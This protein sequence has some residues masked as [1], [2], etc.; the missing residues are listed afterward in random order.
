MLISTRNPLGQLCF[1][2]SSVRSILGEILKITTLVATAKNPNTPK[3]ISAQTEPG[4]G[5]F[6]PP[7]PA[8]R[9]AM[10]G[11]RNREFKSNLFSPHWAPSMPY[12]Q[13]EPR[14]LTAAQ[15]SSPFK[16]EF[17]NSECQKTPTTSSFCLSDLRAR[18]PSRPPGEGILGAAFCFS[19]LSPALVRL[20]IPTK[21]LDS[22][23]NI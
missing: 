16:Q 12:T 1:P 2:S 17:H 11:Y 6:L 14:F 15:S 21:P 13:F 7:L 5:F 20:Q 22:P 18:A 4:I 10:L 9:P 3:N 8:P 19:Q 23:W